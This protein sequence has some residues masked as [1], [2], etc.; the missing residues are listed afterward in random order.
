VRDGLHGGFPAARPVAAQPTATF[1]RPGGRRGTR[2]P[3]PSAAAVQLRLRDPEDKSDPVELLLDI[4]FVS[5]LSQASSLLLHDAHP[6]GV[7]RVLAVLLVSLLFWQMT[8]AA[9]AIVPV[10]AVLRIL[11]IIMTGAFLLMAA[12]VKE[13]FRSQSGGLDGPVLFATATTAAGACSVGMWV[14]VGTADRRWRGNAALLVAFAVVMTGCAWAAALHVDGSV[15]QWLLV[16]YGAS[17]LLCSNTAIAYPARWQ[18]GSRVAHWA[19]NGARAYRER[20]TTAYIVGCCLSLEL[21]EMAG[22]STRTAGPMLPS[23]LALLF[24][25]LSLSCLLYWLYEPLIEPAQHTVD[26][27]NPALSHTR[28]VAHSLGDLY[29][30]LLMF[31]GLVLVA[32]GLRSAFTE[33]TH[34]VTDTLGQTFGT[35]PLV[36]L[37]G[38]VALCL[39]GQVLF[40]LSTL[41][42]LDPLRLAGAIGAAAAIPL[43]RGRPVLVAVLVLL[44]G[45]IVLYA[46]DRRRVS[47][48]DA[49]EPATQH[50]SVTGFELYF[51]FMAAFAF[52][53]VGSLVVRDPRAAGAMRA[54]LILIAVYGCWITYCWAANTSQADRGPL[55]YL[56]VAALFGLILLGLATPG[57]FAHAGLNTR[58]MVFLGA[59][60]AIRF[61]SAAALYCL[62]GRAALVRACLTAGCGAATAGCIATA[63]LCGPL[64]GIALWI[65]AVA[66]EILAVVASA[67]GRKTESPAHLSERFAFLVILG[68]DMSLSGVC[69]QFADTAI[70]AVHIALIGLALAICTLMWWLY[71]D[72]LTHYA[73]H[74]LHHA[75][76]G[77]GM[78]AHRQ[79]V[80]VC[81]AGLHLVILTGM[82]SVG[83]SLRSIAES[84]AEGP[85]AVQGPELTLM[86]AAGLTIGL[87]LYIAA[88][89][90]MWDV[91]A[92]RALVPWLIAAATLASTPLLL[93][94]PAVDALS[95]LVALVGL[96]VVAHALTPAMRAHRRVTHSELHHRSQAAALP[97]TPPA[98][99]L[100]TAARSETEDAST[101]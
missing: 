98:A 90:A 36:E 93:G 26:P 41:W 80:Y 42:R 86:T 3:E 55:R 32:G 29:G 84:A 13:A 62:S 4:T 30:H 21:L 45:V 83:L 57:A 35:E 79:L 22:Q 50:R 70:G 17:M 97:H 60:L 27:R 81:Y 54:L 82:V 101:R 88:I 69:A 25:A 40:S 34:G 12:S 37:Y 73:E 58:A 44:A 63:A 51:D 68:L 87:S 14:R 46:L 6:A 91:L 48:G 11:H 43:L 33:L 31:C 59:Y 75:A 7:L 23:I 67:W 24:A 39:L 94:C 76:A 28:K 18:V 9:T 96:P 85:V 95:L 5:L 77:H 16:G 2:S 10:D 19:I 78:R 38:G 53:Q 56:H 61:G 89:T 8:A 52:A 64:T 15:G 100:P 92:R 99:R 66:C 1:P 72:T 65:T 47:S 74:R 20:Y 71:F 49:V